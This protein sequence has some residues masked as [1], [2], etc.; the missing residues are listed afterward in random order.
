MVRY[1]GLFL[2]AGAVLGSSVA[3]A[4]DDQNTLKPEALI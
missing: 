2:F 3:D 4:A 1:L